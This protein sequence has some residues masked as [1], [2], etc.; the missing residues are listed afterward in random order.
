MN[1]ISLKNAWSSNKLPRLL[2]QV[3]IVF[4]FLY[5]AA[6]FYSFYNFVRGSAVGVT[7]TRPPVVEGFL[8][9]A[10][11][12]AFKAMFA[13]G[14]IDPIHPAGLVI[15]LAVL[16]TA[17]V[18]RRAMC[19]WLCPLGT[20]SEYLSKLGRRVMGKNLRMPKWLDIILLVVKYALFGYVFNMFFTMPAEQAVSFLQ[21]PYY[22]ISDIKMFEFFLNIGTKG[23]MFIG[24]MMVLSFLFKSF[25]CRY[26][27]P[28]GALLGILG[29]F[30][31]I[32][33][34]KNSET[35]IN[36]SKCNLACPNGVDVQGKKSVVMSTECSGCTNCVTSCPK[37]ETLQFK[38]LGILPMK[39]WMFSVAFV[40]LFFA[41]I[42]AAK[43]TGVWESSVGAM[44]YQAIYH[45]MTGF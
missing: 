16:L 44:D 38:L 12:V 5:A 45:T 19:S 28:Y 9:I 6:E 30:S 1:K 40:V 34:K 17:W 41:I 8:P 29:I 23:L 25:W 21:I 32:V 39:P 42:L 36:C 15:F 27:C 11:F 24:L 2:V 26:L 33:L 4:L 13:T 20:L 43:S 7:A 22:T 10:A 35:C 3:F 18:F 31:P 37:P 14:Q